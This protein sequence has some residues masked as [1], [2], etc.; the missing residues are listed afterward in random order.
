[1]KIAILGI[2]AIGSY[3]AAMFSKNTQHEVHL[4]AKSNFS[5]LK[6]DGIIVEDIPEGGTWKAHRFE[7]HQNIE[8]IPL[9][10]I[11]ILTVKVSQNVELLPYIYKLCHAETK[12]ISLQNGLNFE[13]EIQSA[14]PQHALYSGTCWIKVSRLSSSNAIRHDFGKNIKLGRYLLDERTVPLE[15]QD[16]LIKH[17]FESAQLECDLVDNIKSVQLTKLALN[18]PFFVLM[19]R[20]GKTVAEILVDAATDQ[21]RQQ[22]QQE[23]VEA[24]AKLG[25]PV[26]ERYISQVIQNLR[27]MPVTVPASRENLSENMKKDLPFHVEPLISLMGASDIKMPMLEE[28]YYFK[29]YPQRR[30]VTPSI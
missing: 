20:E 10:D 26:D 11:V 16:V 15:E 18:I 13:A 1:M 8:E 27:K 23:I 9:C 28:L 25:S 14:L 19:A 5:L 24:A 4:L 17:L 7:V 6:S 22:L 30:G 3:V 2:G 12:I 21:E 29:L